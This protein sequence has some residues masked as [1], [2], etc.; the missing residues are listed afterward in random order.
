MALTKPED[1]DLN[2]LS[3]KCCNAYLRKLDKETEK[4][5]KPRSNGL[6]LSNQAYQ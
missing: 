1:K 6:K 4:A 2:E 5:N 3:T